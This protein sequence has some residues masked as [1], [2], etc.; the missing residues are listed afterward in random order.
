MADRVFDLVRGPAGF[1]A[2]LAAIRQHHRADSANCRAESKPGDKRKGFH[3][4]A[5]LQTVF[6]LSGGSNGGNYGSS[7]KKRRFGNDK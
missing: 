2:D 3:H 4:I 6:P 5:P 1:F 7:D